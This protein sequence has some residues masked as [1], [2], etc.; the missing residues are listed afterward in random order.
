MSFPY[1]ETPLYAS[2]A[3]YIPLFVLSVTC[4]VFFFLGFGYHYRQS[5]STVP[6]P[7]WAS[8]SRF[9][10]LKAITS[11]NPAEKLINVNKTYG[12][13]AWRELDFVVLIVSGSLARVGPKHLLTSDPELIRRILT[14]RSGYDRGP[15]FDSL[16]IDPHKTN[17]V[18]ER[19]AE[20]HRRLRY[21]IAPSVGLLAKLSDGES[22]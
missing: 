6:G 17:I 11:R 15:W 20:S 21:R 2:L 10:L 8:W 5:L 16:R 4:K 14:P 12:K 22:H 7:R 13:V 1:A 18:S 19:D 9:W 3:L